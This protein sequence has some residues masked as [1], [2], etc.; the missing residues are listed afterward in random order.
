M[1]GLGF[2][3]EKNLGGRKSRGT[4]PWI[5]GKFD[6]SSTQGRKHEETRLEYFYT[7]C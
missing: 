4:V 1:I 5:S 2:D 6:G 7:E 3:G